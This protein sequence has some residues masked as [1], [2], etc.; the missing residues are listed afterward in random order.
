MSYWEKKEEKLCCFGISRK[1]KKS[2]EKWA[3]ETNLL[4]TWTVVLGWLVRLRPCLQYWRTLVMFY[5]GFRDFWAKNDEMWDSITKGDGAQHQKYTWNTDISGIKLEG[6]TQFITTPG[7]SGAL[8]AQAVS[9]DLEHIGS[10]VSFR[11]CPNSFCFF[12]S[13]CSTPESPSNQRKP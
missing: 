5:N 4:L 3:K 13:S 7:K 9:V 6:I 11:D 1:R 10:P 2:F 8:L 12:A